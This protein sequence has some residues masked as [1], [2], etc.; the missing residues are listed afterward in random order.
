MPKENKKPN[1]PDKKRCVQ[2]VSCK[3]VPRKP[4]V[5]RL[6]RALVLEYGQDTINW[7]GDIAREVLRRGGDGLLQQVRE[8]LD[9]TKNNSAVSRS[10]LKAAFGKQIEGLEAKIKTLEAQKGLQR[11]A[12]S[13][14]VAILEKKVAELEEAAAFQPHPTPEQ[15]I[16]A[17][18]DHTMELFARDNYFLS[19]RQL[20]R[21]IKSLADGLEKEGKNWELF[22]GTLAM[23]MGVYYREGTAYPQIL[24]KLATA[25]WDFAT[26][27][28]VTQ[29]SDS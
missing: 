11:F 10:R 21:Y 9:R 7:V 15:D 12:L 18:V 8:R 16:V 29:K 27:F 5:W 3:P 23:R 28:K 25:G 17:R 6:G 22:T 13:H 1:L 26:P 20:K 4:C 19:K 2:A 24:E 14:K